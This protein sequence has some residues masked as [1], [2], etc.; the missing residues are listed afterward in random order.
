MKFLFIP[1]S[2]AAS[3]VGGLLGRQI[4]VKLWGVVDREE[5]PDGSIK[6]TTWR[7][8]VVAAALQG[9]IFAAA[10]VVTDRGARKAFFNLTGSWPG[11]ERPDPEG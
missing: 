7:K 5:P 10:R 8:L 11:Q 4:F 6:E 9:A 1:F 2:I 3:L